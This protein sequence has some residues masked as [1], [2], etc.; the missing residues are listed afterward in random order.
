M[1]N[2]RDKIW[3]IDSFPYEIIR[4]APDQKRAPGNQRTRERKVYKD[5]ICAFDIETTYLP[6]LDQ[7]FMYIWQMQIEDYTII[8]RT[9]DEFIELRR[10]IL[11]VLDKKEWLVIWVHNLSFEFQYLSDPYIYEFTQKEV[12]CMDPRKIL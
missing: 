3:T 7:S 8:G 12:F 2:G 9:W 10:R 11:E 4:S 6:N 5:L 1:E